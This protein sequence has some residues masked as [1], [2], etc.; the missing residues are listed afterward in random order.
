VCNS[1]TA[2]E[3]AEVGGKKNKNNNVPGN[4]FVTALKKT[5]ALFRSPERVKVLGTRFTKKKSRA[6]IM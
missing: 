4:K 5:R 1:I 2:H 3:S 6:L